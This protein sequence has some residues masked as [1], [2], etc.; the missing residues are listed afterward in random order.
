MV[1][2]VPMGEILVGK[3]EQNRPLRRLRHRWGDNIGMNLK[4]I[5]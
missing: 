2:I 5:R 3:P 1:L 4:D